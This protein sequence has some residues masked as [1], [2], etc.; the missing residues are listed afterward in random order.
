[1]KKLMIGLIFL[2]CFSS[3]ASLTD[4]EHLGCVLYTGDRNI[5]EWVL[6]KDGVFHDL[7]KFSI[8]VPDENGVRRVDDFNDTVSGEC[9]E[10]A[11]HAGLECEYISSDN[12]KITIILD[13]VRDKDVY[14]TVNYDKLIGTRT[15]KVHCDINNW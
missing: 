12:K 7:R 10:V 8:T 5:M 13:D 15:H 3:F 2:T 4:A 6:G 9:Y 14:G 1:M 11:A